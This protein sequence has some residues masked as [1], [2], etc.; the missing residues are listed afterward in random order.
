MKRAGKISKPALKGL[1]RDS[2]H[3]GG[4]VKAGN[5]TS[6][7]Q[8]KLKRNSLL[9]YFHQH[10]KFPTRSFAKRKWSVSSEMWASTRRAMISG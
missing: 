8:S 1:R 6:A 7:K 3:K 4:R 5:G 2:G 9:R 10:Q